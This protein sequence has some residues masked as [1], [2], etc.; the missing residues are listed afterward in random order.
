M[1]RRKSNQIIQTET[2]WHMAVS[3]LPD[4]REQARDSLS[5]LLVL[6]ENTIGLKTD[7]ADDP[8]S[9]LDS[10]LTVQH[11]QHTVEQIERPYVVPARKMR[12]SK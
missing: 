10:L 6:F 7:C 5:L 2:V 12:D 1:A 3:K 4:E 11:T 9:D 8:L